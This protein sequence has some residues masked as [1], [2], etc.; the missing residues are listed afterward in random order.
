MGG[1]GFLRFCLP[2]APAATMYCMP[3]LIAISIMSII[4][5][6]YLALGQNDVKRLI[7]YSSVGHMGFVT[8][9]IFLLNS[10]G[11][12]GAILQMLNHGVT[13]GALFICVGIIYERTHSREISDNSALGMIMPIYV[14]FLVIFSLSSL[15]FPGTNSFVGE[16]LVL[17]A[18]FSKYKLVGG[19]AV[20]GA[21]LAA[22]YMLRL[23]QKMVWA[24]SDGHMHH[25][26]KSHLPDLNFRETGTLAFLA[27]FVFWI[28]LNPGPF[29]K[30][31]DTSTL[32]LLQQLEDGRKVMPA[33]HGEY[34]ALL[35]GVGESIRHLIAFK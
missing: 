11:I 30:I 4:F 18:S 24:D 15:A 17:M 3:Y 19:L 6:G 9:G 2:I 25:G 10:V 27:I 14:T 34:H 29:L 21:I 22:A 20:I 8:L 5:G 35:N 1:Y 31:M 13:T 7:A 33:G 12:K 26:E 23:V 16:F 28:G 32:H